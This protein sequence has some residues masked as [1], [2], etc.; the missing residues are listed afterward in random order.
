[1]FHF[2]PADFF[3][4]RIPI[5]LIRPPIP[6]LPVITFPF[7]IGLA[8]GAMIGLYSEAP[9]NLFSFCGLISDENCSASFL[10]CL[11]LSGRFVL[12]AAALSTSVLGFVF[13]P[14]LS[15]LR[16]F[17]FSCSVSVLLQ[18]QSV[19]SF[20]ISFISFGISA[21]FAFPGFLLSSTDA[22][23]ISENF[24][25]RNSTDISKELPLLS[26]VCVIVFLVFADAAYLYFLMPLLLDLLT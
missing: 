23:L 13:L 20:L 12:I 8:L 10:Q 18:S 1:M 21:L 9:W 6:L 19:A 4:H 17:S 22:F 15:L 7:I 26:H 3:S 5:A 24:L 14:F 16:A 11:W 2:K 25:H